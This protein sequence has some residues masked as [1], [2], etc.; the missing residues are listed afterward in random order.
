MKNIFKN[1]ISELKKTYTDFSVMCILIFSVASLCTPLV[2]DVNNNILTIVS[3]ILFILMMVT[4]MQLTVVFLAELEE[5]IQ[6]TKFA[7]KSIATLFMK[8]ANHA[9]VNITTILCCLTLVYLIIAFT[10]GLVFPFGALVWFM[11]PL[12]LMF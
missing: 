11:T 5:A 8:N 6:G 10:T 1:T 12:A 9:D 4:T 7:E 2:L 3:I